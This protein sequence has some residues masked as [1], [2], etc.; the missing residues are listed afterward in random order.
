[1]FRLEDGREVRSQMVPGGS[2]NWGVKEGFCNLRD[3]HVLEVLTSSA[4]IAGQLR[5]LSTWPQ[6]TFLA[7]P[8]GFF[9]MDRPVSPG[10]VSVA[11]NLGLRLSF[12]SPQ[13]THVV[14]F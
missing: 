9:C 6:P 2:S 13:H 7:F 12:L 11:V 5:L 8:A 14:L 3:G 1:M 10:A 4:T